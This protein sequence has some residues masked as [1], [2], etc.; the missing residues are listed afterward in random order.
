MKKILLFTLLFI[1]AFVGVYYAASLNTNFNA[2]RSCKKFAIR[3]SDKDELNKLNSFAAQAK[4]FA[5]ENSYNTGFCFLLDMSL[6]GGQNRFFV[7]DLDRDSILNAGLVA[8]GSCNTRFLEKAAFSN[9]PGCGCSAKGKYK[10]GY[11]YN[12]RFGI[13]YK[14]YGLDKSNSNAFDRNIVLHSY[15]LVPEKEVKPFPICNS[16]GCAMVSDGFIKQLALKIDASQQPIL[17]WIFE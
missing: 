11:R 14:L 17:L 7:Y 9:Q 8:H 10:V 1:L 15:Y 6:P 2:T 4:I 13:A 16:L 12:G 3:I 5:A